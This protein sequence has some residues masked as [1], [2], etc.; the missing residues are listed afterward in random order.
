MSLLNLAP[1]TLEDRYFQEI[2]LELYE[3]HGKH[4]QHGARKS[5]TSWTFDS[6]IAERKDIAEEMKAF[7]EEWLNSYA[8]IFQFRS[9][10]FE[11]V[12]IRDPHNLLL[13]VSEETELNPIHLL[14]NY[15]FAQR[16]NLIEV[17]GRAVTLYKLSFHLPYN[18]SESKFK[19]TK[20]NRLTAFQNC[21]I[22]RSQQ[23]IA[24]PTSLLADLKKEW[25]AGVIVPTMVNQ[26][27]E[28]YPIEVQG[29]GFS[30]D[31]T[32]FTGIDAIM[33]AAINGV[34]IRL[35]D[36]EEFWIT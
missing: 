10:L 7:A 8:P 12:H 32:F 22:R 11:N 34:K 23:G 1:K 4:Q 9:S 3:L 36:E 30:K 21:T 29:D 5:H 6:A 14:R 20:L 16:G 25:L 27:I 24:A 28:S 2:R 13:D 26:G 18:G 31:Y 19:Y 33:T 15:E 17:T 35:M